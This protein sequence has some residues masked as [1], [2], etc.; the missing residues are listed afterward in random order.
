M[1]R[2]WTFFLSARCWV[3]SNWMPYLCKTPYQTY[4]FFF[5]SHFRTPPPHRTKK[6]RWLWGVKFV[7]LVLSVYFSLYYREHVG[8]YKSVHVC[9][10]WQKEQLLFCFIICFILFFSLL[11]YSIYDSHWCWG[12]S[13]LFA[14]ICLC[15]LCGSMALYSEHFCPVALLL[16]RLCVTYLC[17]PWVR[18]WA[19]MPLK[20]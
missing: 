18:L 9:H 6:K 17:R 20:S 11:L 5:T 13:A 8:I 3:N 15:S 7:Y 14:V 4:L 12:C 10:E 1:Y 2:S 19:A 16:Y